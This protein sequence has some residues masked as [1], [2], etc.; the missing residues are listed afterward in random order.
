MFAPQTEDYKRGVSYVRD[1]YAAGL[2]DIE[3]FTHDINTFNA[4]LKAKAPT[5][6]VFIGPANNQINAAIGREIGK[7]VYVTI[8]PVQESGSTKKPVWLPRI[9]PVNKNISM[10]ITK[11]CKD[12]NTLLAWANEQYKP[13]WALQATYGKVGV[14]LE[15]L[16]G[17]KYKPFTFPED[18]D[19]QKAATAAK[20]QYVAYPNTSGV[21]P[22]MFVIE[23]NTAIYDVRIINKMYEP[24]FQL[25]KNS[26][27]SVLSTPEEADE[28]AALSTDIIEY[29]RQMQAKWICEGG[30]EK[31]WDGYLKKLNDMK[32][33]KYISINQAQLDRYNKK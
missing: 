15:D 24:Y 16:G 13:E 26:F 18:P 21:T 9:M 3:A 7:E 28:L 27:P 12:P 8:P 19:K 6:G 4:K 25:P 17:G 31:D 10:I 14:Q 32:L 29:V 23:Q 2:V 30:I 5:V 11:A 22:N 33:S 20:T 1:L